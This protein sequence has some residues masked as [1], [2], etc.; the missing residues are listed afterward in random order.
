[1]KGV[2]CV[3]CQS[4]L[5][6][7]RNGIAAAVQRYGNACPWCSNP[8]HPDRSEAARQS[9]AHITWAREVRT[10]KDD[11][12]IG[13]PFVE[14]DGFEFKHAP[15]VVTEERQDHIAHLATFAKVAAPGAEDELD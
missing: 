7:F 1:M 11:K 2:F 15:S 5:G 12:V 8:I 3:C 6:Y 10:D 9:A 14:V 13:H 4:L